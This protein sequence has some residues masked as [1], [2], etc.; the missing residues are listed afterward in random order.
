MNCNFRC[1]KVKNHLQA[2]L[3]LDIQVHRN[4]DVRTP[5]NL[6]AKHRENLSR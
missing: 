4:W 1:V 3:S 5:Q 6:P 2:N